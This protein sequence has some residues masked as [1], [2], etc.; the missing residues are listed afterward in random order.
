M[1]DTKS[2]GQF[3]QI[4]ATM[5]V[6]I[7]EGLDAFGEEIKTRTGVAANRSKLIGMLAS[8]AVG[9]R[10]SIDYSKI[11]DDV[12]LQRQLLLALVRFGH[13]QEPPPGG[14]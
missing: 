4:S 7:R 5:R 1:S 13:E 8:L 11:E 9:A 2:K 3:V 14:L 6:G 12:T 10:D